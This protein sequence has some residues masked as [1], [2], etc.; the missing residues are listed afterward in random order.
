MPRHGAPEQPVE[1]RTMP[2]SAS[3]RGTIAFLGVYGLGFFVSLCLVG[4]VGVG[5]MPLF[6]LQLDNLGW[7]QTWL[8]QTIFD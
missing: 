4:I 1:P 7:A 2:L 8:I 3:G 6:P 5:F